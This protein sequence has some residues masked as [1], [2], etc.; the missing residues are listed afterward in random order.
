MAEGKG[1]FNDFR[2]IYRLVADN[3]K[4]CRKT[5]GAKQFKH[6]TR[7]ARVGAIVKGEAKFF[8]LPRLAT[9]GFAE[10]ITADAYNATDKNREQHHNQKGDC[11]AEF[12]K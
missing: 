8:R 9:I 4:S 6:V 1:L 2:M 7:K 11:R 10:K 3:K 5:I 12:R